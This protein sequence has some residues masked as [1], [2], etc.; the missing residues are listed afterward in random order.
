MK[1]SDMWPDTIL[2][3]LNEYGFLTQLTAN[4]EGG[5]RLTSDY[6]GVGTVEESATCL[7]IAVQKHCGT[8]GSGNPCSPSLFVGRVGDYEPDCRSVLLSACEQ[9]ERHAPQCIFGDIGERCD[10]AIWQSIQ[11]EVDRSSRH[12]KARRK[13]KGSPQGRQSQ[14][15]KQKVVKDDERGIHWPQISVKKNGGSVLQTRE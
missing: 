5:L 10:A 4:L 2:K 12:S 7:C 3:A 1:E 14:A 8:Q 9:G 15:T 11:K 13:R 6:S